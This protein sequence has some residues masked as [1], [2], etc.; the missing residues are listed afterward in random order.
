VSRAE[1]IEVERRKIFV[2]LEGESEAFDGGLRQGGLVIEESREVAV[3]Q[4]TK[5]QP[6]LPGRREVLHLHAA[7]ERSDLKETRTNVTNS[8][9]VWGKC[10]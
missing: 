6:V 2:Y 1:E 5:G 3:R 10:M 4:R 9:V 8:P 7:E